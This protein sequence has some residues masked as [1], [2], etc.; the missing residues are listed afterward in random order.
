[1]RSFFNKR[2]KIFL[3]IDWSI[4]QF[5]KRIDWLLHR[6]YLE[7]RKCFASTSQS[8]RQISITCQM[9]YY[10]KKILLS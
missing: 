8:V 3:Y 9:K 6:E 10:P 4:E 7:F 2:G 5:I 1:M